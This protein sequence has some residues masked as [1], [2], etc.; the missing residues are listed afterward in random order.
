MFSRLTP[1]T[2][3]LSRRERGAFSSFNAAPNP[4][5]LPFFDGRQ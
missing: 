1:L 5:T 3:P 4:K 2:L